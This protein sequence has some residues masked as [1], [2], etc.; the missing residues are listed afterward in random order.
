MSNWFL[1]LWCQQLQ[2]KLKRDSLIVFRAIH[3]ILKI[4]FGQNDSKYQIKKNILQKEQVGLSILTTKKF[5]AYFII[6][7]QS[8]R[9]RS[10]INFLV[11]I[12]ECSKKTIDMMFVLDGSGSVGDY[13]FEVVKNWTMKMAE[14]FY[15]YD[16]ET[17]IGVVQYSHYFETQ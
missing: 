8:V 9:W 15:Q 2:T 4:Y 6:D 12:T 7:K 14:R 5:V 13:N 1:I 10:V 16:N 11:N 17:Q 3:T